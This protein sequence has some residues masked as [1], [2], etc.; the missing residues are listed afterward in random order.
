MNILLIYYRR[1]VFFTGYLS[2]CSNSDI[3]FAEL[4][5]HFP[6]NSLMVFHV[7]T[8]ESDYRKICLNY[9]WVYFTQ[10]NFIFKRR[11]N[12]FTCYFCI[13]FKNA[14][15]NAMLTRGLSYKDYIYKLL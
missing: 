5:K 1:D 9:Q 13:T 14:K 6:T 12:S 11:I 8:N 10:L 15:T 2:Y 3:V 7:I 4:A